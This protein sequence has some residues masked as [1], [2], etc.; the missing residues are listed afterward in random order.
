MNRTGSRDSES[1]AM[2]S[3][4]LSTCVLSPLDQ[5]CLYFVLRITI[6]AENVM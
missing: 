3:S 1:S 2:K 6:G 5:S 4:N